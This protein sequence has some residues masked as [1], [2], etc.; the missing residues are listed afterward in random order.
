MKERQNFPIFLHQLGWVEMA[1]QGYS[2]KQTELI[3]KLHRMSPSR[4]EV[5]KEKS[6]ICDICPRN[7]RSPDY[8]FEQVV[9]DWDDLALRIA[10]GRI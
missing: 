6:V 7:P 10:D 3:L 8:D 5:S 4:L 1:E 9:C 2:Q